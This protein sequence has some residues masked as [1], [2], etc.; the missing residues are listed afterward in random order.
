MRK[1]APSCQGV[2][3]LGASLAHMAG[4]AYGEVLCISSTTRLLSVLDWKPSSC[5]KDLCQDPSSGDSKSKPVSSQL[6]CASQRS[7]YLGFV[8]HG[9]SHGTCLLMVP[10]S[11]GA[12]MVPT[13][14]GAHF[15]WYPPNT[16]PTSHGAHLCRVFIFLWCCCFPQQ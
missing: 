7:L 1:R 16:V 6:P 10:S 2:A 8:L 12:C 14:P 5:P 4:P 9:I 15:I 11:H 13:S 3:R